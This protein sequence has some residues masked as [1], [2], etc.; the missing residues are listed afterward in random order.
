[1]QLVADGPDL[2]LQV[3]DAHAGGRLAIFCGAGVSTRAG[4]PL[5]RGLVDRVYQELGTNPV[6]AEQPEWDAKNFDRVL[7]LLEARFSRAL[8]RR[9]VARILATPPDPVLQTHR[10]IIDL[11]RDRD[12]KLQLVTTNFDLVVSHHSAE[13]P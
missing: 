7:N 13:R 8:V 1:M 4:L 12:G 5:F 2:P 11:A 10:A 9:A 3:L 6:D